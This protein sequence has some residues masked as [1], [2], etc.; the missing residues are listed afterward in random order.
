MAPKEIEMLVTIKQTFV[1]KTTDTGDDE[2]NRENAAGVVIQDLADGKLDDRIPVDCSHEVSRKEETL[3]ES[4][5]AR[6]DS[7]WFPSGSKNDIQ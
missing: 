1:V 4:P 7:W 5:A 3:V 2:T 6:Q